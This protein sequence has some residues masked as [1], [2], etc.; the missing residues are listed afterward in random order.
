[1]AVVVE[2]GLVVVGVCWR[3]E[4]GRDLAEGELVP[5]DRGEERVGFDGRGVASRA[6]AFLRVALEE[7]C[8]AILDPLSA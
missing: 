1:M 3:F 7:L 5:V 6:E 4:R 8:A 2:I